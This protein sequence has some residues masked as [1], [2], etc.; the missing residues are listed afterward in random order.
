MLCY[1]YL[2]IPVLFSLE[3]LYDVLLFQVLHLGGN[4]FSILFLFRGEG[5]FVCFYFRRLF[6]LVL[7]IRA[8]ILVV[9]MLFWLAICGFQLVSIWYM[10]KNM[11]FITQYLFMLELASFPF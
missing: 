7:T 4:V 2:F 11:C 10:L 8:C 9:D 1:L 3:A 5:F 6:F